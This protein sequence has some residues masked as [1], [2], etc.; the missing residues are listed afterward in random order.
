MFRKFSKQFLHYMLHNMSKLAITVAPID[1]VTTP[2]TKQDVSKL[3]DSPRVSLVYGCKTIKKE[4][5][6]EVFAQ[7]DVIFYVP[8]DEEIA[9]STQKERQTILDEAKKNEIIAISLATQSL[10]DDNKK[11]QKKIDTLQNNLKNLKNL[12]IQIQKKVK[13]LV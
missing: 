11:K 9:K 5:C 2:M 13:K 3:L 8:T 10:E 1:N 4:N 12:K 7:S 6:N